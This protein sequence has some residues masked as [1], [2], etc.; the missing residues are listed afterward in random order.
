MHVY[1][2]ICLY[3]Y[4]SACISTHT[5]LYITANDVPQRT[6]HDVSSVSSSSA[7]LIQSRFAIGSRGPCSSLTAKQLLTSKVIPVGYSLH[8][9]LYCMGMFRGVID[10]LMQPVLGALAELARLCGVTAVGVC[11]RLVHEEARNQEA[12][13]TPCSISPLQDLVPRAEN[14][15]SLQKGTEALVHQGNAAARS[16][17]RARFWSTRPGGFFLV[18]ERNHAHNQP[19]SRLCSHVVVQA[20][21]RYCM[22][23]VFRL[24]KKIIQSNTL[25]IYTYTYIYMPLHAQIYIYT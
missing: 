19:A 1:V 14:I 11:L 24:S 18:E 8:L 4:V 23:D 9:C 13:S 22:K 6:G 5:M 25:Y 10:R 7:L 15:P 3:M 16:S 12:G 21:E 2:C 17:I 20:T